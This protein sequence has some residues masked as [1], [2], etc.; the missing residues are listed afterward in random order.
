[1]VETQ[2]WGIHAGVG[3]EADSFVLGKNLIVM[4]WPAFGDLSRFKTRE[5]FKKHYKTAYPNDKPGAIPLNAGQLYRFVHEAKE[6]DLIVYPSKHS[7]TIH[8]GKIIGPYQYQTQLNQRYP[9]HRKVEWLKEIPRTQFSQGALYESGSAMSFFQIKNY[10]EEFQNALTGKSIAPPVETDPGISSLSE[11]AEQT[12]TDFILKTLSQE[13]KGVPLE[14]FIA[15]LLTR[16]GY[17]TRKTV[18]NTPGVDIIAHEDELGFK[19]P[20][21]KVQVKSTG[22]NVSYKDVS[23]LSGEVSQGEFG[24]IVTLGDFTREAV[25][26]T[27]K[28]QNLRLINGV[29]LVELILKHYDSL[30]TRYKGLIPLR[31]VYLPEAIERRED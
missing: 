30:D 12:I 10:A 27:K 1:M 22:G 19:G 21:I 29:E 18:T 5:E 26:F 25:D 6:G 9:N 16:M 17:K 20:I 14:D 24:L 7:R 8:I 4:G 23:S 13:L 28:R 31:R 11:A 2:I 15:H 3:G